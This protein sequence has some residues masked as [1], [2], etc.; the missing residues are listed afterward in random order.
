MISFWFVFAEIVDELVEIFFFGA[1]YL[2]AED[3]AQNER[4]VSHFF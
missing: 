2:F 4:V 1:F 3:A